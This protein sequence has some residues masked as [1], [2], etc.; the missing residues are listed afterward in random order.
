MTARERPVSPVICRGN[1][2]FLIAGAVDLLFSDKDETFKDGD[3]MVAF[4][5]GELLSLIVPKGS[6]ARPFFA[7]HDLARQANG[8][9][10]AGTLRPFAL[11]Y[12]V[13]TGPFQRAVPRHAASV[14][15]RS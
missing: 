15:R 12:F 11:F 4:E 5:T 7:Q 9:V 3:G 13:P 1:G 2:S 10:A 6:Q 14:I 8:P